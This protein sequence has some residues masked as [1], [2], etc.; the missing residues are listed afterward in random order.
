MN[1]AILAL[2]TAFCQSGQDLLARRLLKGS[3]LTSRLVMGM[4]CLVASLAALPLALL[5][6]PPPQVPGLLQALV[7]IALVNGLAFWAYGRALSRGQLSLVV[8]LLNLSPLVLLISA[9]LML[10]ERPGAG[11]IAGMVLIVVGALRLG[12][13]DREE[14]AGGLLEIPGA[15]WML[16][17]AL[18][19]GIGAGIDKVGVS[20]SGTFSWVVGLNVVV[21]LPLALSALVAGEGRSLAIPSV[22]ERFLWGTKGMLL[23]FGVISAL[24]MAIQMEAVQ[25]TAVVNVIAIK[26][27]STLFSAAAGGMFFGEPRPGLRLPAVALMVV[28]AVLVLLSPIG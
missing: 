19:W 3:G 7:A 9:W 5:P 14:R 8:P 27:L 11:S 25:R 17:V 1:W 22:E 12:A 28:G 4:G 6:G 10:G 15:R 26:R 23:L 16:L 2:L 20:A 21:G 18:L 24:G 13:S